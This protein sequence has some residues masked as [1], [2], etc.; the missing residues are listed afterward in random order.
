VA[1]AGYSDE[2]LSAFDEWL[3]SPWTREALEEEQ[4]IARA[5]QGDG[6]VVAESKLTPEQIAWFR[7]RDEQAQLE[8]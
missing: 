7:A 4:A 2:D 6:V 8:A 5:I 3:D 1:T